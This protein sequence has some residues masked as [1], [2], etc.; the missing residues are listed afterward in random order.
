MS[1][2]GS[3]STERRSFNGATI[4][5]D[6]GA[7][8][9]DTG[10]I[11]LVYKDDGQP[12]SAGNLSA[13]VR[14]GDQTVTW[15]PGVPNTGNLGGT[16]RTL[17]QA[18]GPKPL[19]DGLL[20]RDGWY[21]LDDSKSDLFVGDWVQS[22]PNKDANTDWYLFGYGSD[23]RAALQSMATIG[24]PVPLPRKY[25][26]GIWYSRYWSFTA[27]AF[28]QIVQEYADHGFPLD[29]MVMDMGWHLNAVPP[30]LKG[31]GKIDTWTG[32]TWD[33][34]LIPDPAGL[35]NWMHEQGLHVTLNDHPAAGVQPHEEMYADFM[36]AMGRDPS[37]SETI[38]FDAGSKKYLDT[39]WQY[40]HEPRQ[41]QG[42]DFWWLDWQQYPFTRSIPDLQNLAMLNWYYF[43]KAAEGGR[44]GQSFSRWAGW[45][46]HRYPIEFSGD[47]D[48]G[49]R[50]LAFEVPFTATAG[51]VGAFFWSHDIGGH[52]G[53]RNPESY[54]RWCQ[55]GALSAA[56]R[57]HSTHDVATDRRPWNY[58]DWA[59]ASMHVSFR[60]RAQLMPYLYTAIHQATAD[61]VP[62]T[63]PM[64]FDHPEIETAY[65]QSQEYQFG[66]DLLVA[67]IVTEGVGDS[68]VASQAVWFPP[69]GDWYDYFT[70]ERVRR[71]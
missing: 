69:G 50:M 40:T 29:T 46:D 36:R 54:T 18:S 9:I 49:F 66:D 34:A 11:S 15:R 31:V 21:L 48:T 55:F 20:S 26:L 64:Y 61:S 39:F 1:D 12:F 33:P 17:D 8:T 27:D 6:G 57:S 53:G 38:P 13:T 4:R 19:G 3:R 65:H 56:L 43:T 51:N 14:R 24:G 23:Y 7:L 41:Q 45:G 5:N 59:E 52:M 60:L 44:R 67:P 30:A 28:K 10:Q 68:R 2:R 62:F 22:R 42:V 37:T 35:L 63:R 25:T 71:W 16:I 47:A 70:G 58:P 32:Y